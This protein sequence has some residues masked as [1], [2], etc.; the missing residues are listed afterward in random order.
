MRKP[1]G[2]YNGDTDGIMRNYRETIDDLPIVCDSIER[3]VD[4]LNFKLTRRGGGGCRMQKAK[5]WT[6]LKANSNKTVAVVSPKSAPPPAA[7]V[8][9]RL[10]KLAPHVVSNKEYHLIFEP[11]KECVWEYFIFQMKYL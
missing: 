8:H 10:A 2:I 6:T 1:S 11:F 9:P 7:V 3:I 5:F 4:Y